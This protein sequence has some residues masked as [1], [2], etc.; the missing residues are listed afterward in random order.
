MSFQHSLKHRV[1][2]PDSLRKAVPQLGCYS[3]QTAII[4]GFKIRGRDSQKA[5]I[6]RSE[7]RADQVLEAQLN[8]QGLSMKSLICQ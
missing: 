4:S 8:K 1:S 3:L 5:L 2:Q 7:R 6:G